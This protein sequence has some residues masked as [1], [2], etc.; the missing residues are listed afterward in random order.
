MAKEKPS[1]K[2]WLVCPHWD[3]QSN[4]RNWIFAAWDDWCDAP[5]SQCIHWHVKR[6]PKRDLYA[7]RPDML[8]RCLTDK[9]KE[10]LLHTFGVNEGRTSRYNRNYFYADFNTP[11]WSIEH[12]LRLGVMERG[13]RAPA[14]FD[15]HPNTYYR[16]TEAGKK[17]ALSLMFRRSGQ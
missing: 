13:Q 4:P 1:I 2:G 15:S 3:S 14:S 7:P 12:M 16:L 9:Q 6:D 8:A 17:A 11:G 10:I 5:R